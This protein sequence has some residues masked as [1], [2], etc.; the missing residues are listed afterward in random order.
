MRRL[1]SGQRG[2]AMLETLVAV[3]VFSVGVLGYLRLLEMSLRNADSAAFRQQAALLAEAMVDRLR[4]DRDAALEGDYDLALAA[5]PAGQGEA[6]AALAAWRADLAGTLPA[7]GGGVD[8]DGAAFCTVTVVWDDRRATAGR[9][10]Q[11]FTLRAR[12]R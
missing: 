2:V 1:R 9:E 8:C 6:A 12:I 10:Q 4:A 5:S 3:L 11:F 7:G